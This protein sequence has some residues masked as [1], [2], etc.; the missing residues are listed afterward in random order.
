[1]RGPRRDGHD[2]YVE[3]ALGDD[4]SALRDEITEHM[5]RGGRQTEAFLAT[6]QNKIPRRNSKEAGEPASE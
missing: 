5:T 4:F 2:R 6:R 1:M 3:T